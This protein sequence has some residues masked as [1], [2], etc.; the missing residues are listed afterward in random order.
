MKSTIFFLETQR[1]FFDSS[2]QSEQ[3]RTKG[4]APHLKEENHSGAF[5]ILLHKVTKALV[6]D[7][8]LLPLR[9][10][11]LVLLEVKRLSHDGDDVINVLL[12]VKRGDVSIAVIANG[13]KTKAASSR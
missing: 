2:D 4:G 7:D 12:L 9:Q 3:V 11:R 6:E 8:L 1:G 10:H 13:D 5:F